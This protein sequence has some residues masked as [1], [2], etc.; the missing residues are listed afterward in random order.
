MSATVARNPL[1]R[2]Q[3]EP[4]PNTFT[5]LAIIIVNGTLL[6]FGADARPVRLPYGF[7]SFLIGPVIVDKVRLYA[8][9]A[10]RCRRPVRNAKPYSP[11]TTTSRAW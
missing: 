5:P 10:A 7:D 3:P 11:A 8:A 4:G 6:I 9:A 1:R 2:P